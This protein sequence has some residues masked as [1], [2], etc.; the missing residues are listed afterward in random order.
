MYRRAREAAGSVKKNN[1]SKTVLRELTARVHTLDYEI[2]LNR[3]TLEIAVQHDR[4]AE[5]KLKWYSYLDKYLD[6]SW[7]FGEVLVGYRCGRFYVYITFHRDAVPRE[8]RVVMGVDLNFNNITQVDLSG[9]LVSIGVIPF[10][11]LKRALHLRKLAEDLQRKHPRNWR[12]LRWV[13]RARARWLSRAKNVLIDA[14]H[15]VSKRLVEVARGYNAVVVFEDLKKLRE[16]GNGGRKLSWE[17]PVWCYRR[18]QEYVEYKALIESIKVIYVNPA[19]TSR[20]SPSGKKVEFVNYRFVELGGAITSRDVV[21]SWNFALKGFKQMRGSR[22]RWSPDSPRG[23]AVKTRAMR[24]NPEA[25]T[26]HLELFTV[27]CLG[28]TQ[29]GKTL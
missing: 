12:F 1:G 27:N 10:K 13:R 14:T 23:E 25:R 20:K 24:G 2:D 15:R 4:W 29:A 18:M 26:K 19:G 5:L 3:K 7:R 6:G 22:V 9:N 16:N 28:E 17:E 8:P 21:A 11:G